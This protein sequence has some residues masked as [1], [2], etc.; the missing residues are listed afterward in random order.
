MKQTVIILALLLAITS[1]PMLA[2]SV[3]QAMLMSALLPGSGE[4]Y[5]GDTTRG[6][7]FLTTDVILLYSIFN[8]DQ[9][10]GMLES[11]FKRY[12]Y[13]NADIPLNRQDD[14]YD[15]IH[16]WQSSNE[17][18]AYYEM[19]ARNYFL[20]LNYEPELYN[21]YISTHHYEGDLAW[22]WQNERNWKKYKEIRR[23]RNTMIVNRKL[24]IGAA[25]ANRVISIMDA[26]YVI[27]SGNKKL[28]TSLNFAPMPNLNGAQFNLQME[29]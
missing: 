16:R 8:F 18:N 20:L 13:A 5:A 27:R 19:V 9:R 15:V 2:K 12:A 4:I 21:E 1:S 11:N 7:F 28:N 6:V 23:D 3:P 29:F 17:Y 25:I 24:A 26:R 22:D 10:A 14:Y